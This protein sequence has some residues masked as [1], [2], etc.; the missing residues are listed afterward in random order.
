M[1]FGENARASNLGS[2]GQVD[3]FEYQLVNASGSSTAKLYIRIDTPNAEIT[4]NP[5][6]PSAP[7]VVIPVANND[8]GTTLIM[9]VPQAVES[10]AT[11]NYGVLVFGGSGQGGS[12]TVAAGKTASVDVVAQLG[13]VGVISGTTFVVQKEMS[14]NVWTDFRALTGNPATVSGL[15]A[16]T[17]RFKATTGSVLSAGTVTVNEINHFVSYTGHVV[18]VASMHFLEKQNLVA[19]EGSQ[20]AP[21]YVLT[22][23]GREASLQQGAGQGA[24]R[25]GQAQGLFAWR[26]LEAGYRA[27][28]QWRRLCQGGAGQQCVR[29][30][31]V[32]G[33]G[34]CDFCAQCL[35]HAWPG[36]RQTAAR[37]LPAAPA[38]VA[39]RRR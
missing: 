9:L 34:Q 21:R 5:A 33:P 1:V 3:T 6:D 35:G 7:G 24:R 19:L 39:K 23:T 22:A 11:F 15:E 37:R 4:W 2:I 30:V 31:L 10:T 36:Q 14:P 17:Y 27:R 28:R 26:Q 20:Q 8:L 12:F 13:G 29:A 18:S 25:V 32:P 16:G 38:V